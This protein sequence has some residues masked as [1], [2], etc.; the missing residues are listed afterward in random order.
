MYYVHSMPCLCEYVFE[1]YSPLL[2]LPSITLDTHVGRYFF[3]QGQK[4]HLAKPAQK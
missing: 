3:S 4:V 2:I 1:K